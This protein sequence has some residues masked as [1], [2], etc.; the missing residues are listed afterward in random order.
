MKNKF[1]IKNELESYC[2]IDYF[3]TEEIPLGNI[4]T[5][6]EKKHFL[7]KSKLSFIRIPQKP[8]SKLIN[9]SEI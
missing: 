3:Y 8:I 7:T 6:F 1:N 4:H 2:P 9:P 5:K